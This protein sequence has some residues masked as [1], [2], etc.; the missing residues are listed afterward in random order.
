MSPLLGASLGCW[1]RRHCPE[2]HLLKTS[3]LHLISDL[4]GCCQHVVE[5]SIATVRFSR[6]NLLVKGEADVK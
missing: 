3:M 5:N 4:A 2:I 6:T 1:F